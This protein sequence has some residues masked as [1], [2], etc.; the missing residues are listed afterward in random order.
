M[1][2]GRFVGRD[3]SGSEVSESKDIVAGARMIE[4]ASMEELKGFGGT[5][6]SGSVRLKP[7][8]TSTTVA[9]RIVVGKLIVFKSISGNSTIE[10]A[11]LNA[12]PVSIESGRFV[13]IWSVGISKRE[14]VDKVMAVDEL[15][16]ENDV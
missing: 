2:D 12:T 10:V 5:V 15:S 3:V 13:E 11:V 16:I 8:E 9:G 7:V 1:K 14:P 6:S 4:E